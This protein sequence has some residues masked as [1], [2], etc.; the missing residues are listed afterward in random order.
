MAA[1]YSFSLISYTL[2]QG[3]ACMYEERLYFDNEL[4]HD[5]LVLSMSTPQKLW[6][7]S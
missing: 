3:T 4:V 2:M 5:C 1:I 6:R 7:R